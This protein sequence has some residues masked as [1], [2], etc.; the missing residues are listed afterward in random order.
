MKESVDYCVAGALPLGKQLLVKPGFGAFYKICI[1]LTAPGFS[2]GM[3]SINFSRS[4]QNLSLQHV[5]SS[6]LT[7]DRSPCIGNMES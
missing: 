2:C 4:M 7:G 3:K 6:S 1:Y 5:G